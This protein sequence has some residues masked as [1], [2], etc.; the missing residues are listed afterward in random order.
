MNESNQTLFEY[1]C[2]IVTFGAGSQEVLY[3][4]TWIDV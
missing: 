2:G 3:P 4:G 1:C